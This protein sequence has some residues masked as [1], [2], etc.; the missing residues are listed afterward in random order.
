MIISPSFDK[1][2]ELPQALTTPPQESEKDLEGTPEY[3]EA[4]AILAQV[5]LEDSQNP[6]DAL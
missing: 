4:Q 2:L 1:K 3:V 6:Q 5:P